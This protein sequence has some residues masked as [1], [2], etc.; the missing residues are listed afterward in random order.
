MGQEAVVVVT[1]PLA[2]PMVLLS[3]ASVSVVE[4]EE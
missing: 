4:V 3:V 1:K 2:P